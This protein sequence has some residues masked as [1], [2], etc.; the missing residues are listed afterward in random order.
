M[1]I[2]YVREVK[3]TFMQIESA[4]IDN[5]QMKMI[6]NNHIPGLLEINYRMVNGKTRY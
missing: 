5:Y 2:E 3:D 1:E 6:M 4:K